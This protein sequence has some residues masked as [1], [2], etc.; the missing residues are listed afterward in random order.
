M[1]KARN[2]FEVQAREAAARI[3]RDRELAEQLSFLPEPAEP[4]VPAPAA[5]DAAGKRTGRPPGS[6]NKGSSQLRQWLAEQG[7]TLP[8]AQLAQIA[9]LAGGG[10][11]VGE[12]IARAERVIAWMLDGA[13][14]SGTERRKALTALK[15]D[16]FKFLFAHARQAAEALLPYGTP[17][18]APDVAVQ[19]NVTFVVPTAPAAP[20]RP[21][22]G[23]R[24][25][26]PVPG[27]RMAPPPLPG[28]MQQDQSLSEGAPNGSDAESRT[29]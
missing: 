12:T 20:G 7:Y 15:V 26:N 18:A 13:E 8:E 28:E 3:D 25:V 10:D 17:K 5:R 1:A 21:G 16:M 22:D 19:Q 14:L 4:A 23:A 29:E 2:L 9:G 6:P 11:V 27:G 24:V